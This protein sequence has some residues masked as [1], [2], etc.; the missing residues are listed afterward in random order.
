MKWVGYSP[1][2]RQ[3]N[4]TEAIRENGGIISRR[5]IISTDSI[6]MHNLYRFNNTPCALIPSQ[7]QSVS[8]AW[9]ACVHYCTWVWIW[10]GGACMW[11]FG[12]GCLLKVLQ[13][14]GVPMHAASLPFCHLYSLMPFTDQIKAQMTNA[15]RLETSVLE[16][17]VHPSP[18]WALLVTLQFQSPCGQH[19]QQWTSAH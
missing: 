14:A 4:N 6:V 15:Q 7:L 5:C 1:Q 9:F 11:I 13:T 3:G 19:L 8:F 2:H 16:H 12:G 18:C 17:T 10:L